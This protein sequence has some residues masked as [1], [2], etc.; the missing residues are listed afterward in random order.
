MAVREQHHT[1]ARQVHSRRAPS[2]AGDS[3]L[4]SQRGVRHA[5]HTPKCVAAHA[6]YTSM[7][8][9]D[10][11]R[12]SLAMKSPA[13]GKCSSKSLSCTE[14][15]QAKPDLLHVGQRELLLLFAGQLE[16]DR[17]LLMRQQVGRRHEIKSATYRSLCAMNATC[18]PCGRPSGFWVVAHVIGTAACGA[19]RHHSG[20]GGPR[21]AV[22]RT[23]F[24]VSKQCTL[25]RESAAPLF[26]RSSKSRGSVSSDRSGYCLD[27]A[28]GSNL[29]LHLPA[30]GIN[31]ARERHQSAFASHFPARS[32]RVAVISPQGKRQHSAAEA[33]R[34]ERSHAL[35]RTA[36]AHRGPVPACRRAVHGCECSA[37]RHS[38]R[39]IG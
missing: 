34:Q 33:S 19:A 38:Q 6:E 1:G 24:A 35:R 5:V 4:E 22:S 27:A 2:S 9:D 20:S 23:A 12:A 28:G 11:G 37:R 25:G 26:P 31:F 21:A 10:T 7:R 29:V 8:L 17:H 36:D 3:I 15:D 18:L 16:A 14:L 13:A 39:P 30:D 32:F